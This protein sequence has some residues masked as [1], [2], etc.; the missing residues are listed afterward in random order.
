MICSV[1]T[2]NIH[3]E[4][5]NAKE[6]TL[7]KDSFPRVKIEPSKFSPKKLRSG[8]TCMLDEREHLKAFCSYVLYLI[9]LFF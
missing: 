4:C 2:Q 1:R 7:A 5:G 8:V 9:S 3:T 6:T